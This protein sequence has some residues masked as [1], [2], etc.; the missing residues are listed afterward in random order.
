MY[1]ASSKRFLS[2]DLIGGSIHSSQSINPYTYCNNDPVNLIDPTG[3]WDEKGEY[4]NIPDGQRSAVDQAGIRAATQAYYAATDQAGRDAAH[5]VAMQIRNNPTADAP[6]PTGYTGA[7]PPNAYDVLYTAISVVAKNPKYA[8]ALGDVMKTAQEWGARIGLLQPEVTE[9]AVAIQFVEGLSF[10]GEIHAAVQGH[11][12]RRHSNLV[13][14]AHIVLPNGRTGRADLMTR[15]PVIAGKYEI[16]E[17][18]PNTQAASGY[19]QL[20]NYVTGSHKNKVTG[21]QAGITTGNS[22]IIQQSSFIYI[23]PS[24]GNKYQ[25]SYADY[26]GGLILYS[27]ERKQEEPAYNP[28]A[29]NIPV[30]LP[31]PKKSEN[32]NR[33]KEWQEELIP[34]GAHAAE[35]GYQNSGV[36]FG[37]FRH[38]ALNPNTGDGPFW[39]NW[40]LDKLG[41]R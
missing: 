9:P 6:I 19:N 37:L 16:W 21:I 2:A 28:T 34:G 15:M 3:M 29:Q 32:E 40:L 27:Y 30:S 24:T 36:D 8:L 33:E 35:R 13:G 26:G 25:V 22:K 1:A 12:L 38:D 7:Y 10:P 5:A 39:I 20:A 17:I 4:T 14:E 41:I 23:S 11:I 31:T 18:K